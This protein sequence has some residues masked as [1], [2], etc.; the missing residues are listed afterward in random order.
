MTK[1]QMRPGASIDV[2]GHKQGTKL[3]NAAYQYAKKLLRESGEEI[4][5]ALRRV[6]NGSNPVYRLWRVS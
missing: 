2:V 5:F 1:T 4:Q 6:T 3:R